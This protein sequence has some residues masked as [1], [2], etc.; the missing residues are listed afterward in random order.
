MH[1][2]EL[3]NITFFAISYADTAH[4]THIFDSDIDE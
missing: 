2:Y 1:G 3:S 4:W